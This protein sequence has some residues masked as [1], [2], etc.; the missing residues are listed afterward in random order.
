MNVMMTPAKYAPHL[1][2]QRLQP[3]L[4]AV[5]TILR[6]SLLVSPAV[7]LTITIITRRK[8]AA[9]TTVITVIVHPIKPMP[10]SRILTAT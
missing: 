1:L 9:T 5:Q 7:M 6:L 3:H 10:I 2:K 8:Q 4:W